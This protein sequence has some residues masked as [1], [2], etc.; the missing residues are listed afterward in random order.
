MWSTAT[1]NGAEG[2]ISAILLSGL[3]NVY[4]DYITTF[5]EYQQQ[6]Y[7]G[8]STIYGPHTQRAHQQQYASLFDSLL[9]V[10]NEHRADC[11]KIAESMVYSTGQ[12]SSVLT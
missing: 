10:N 3:S 5:E 1:D 11:R 4:T 9:K 12:N 8:A 2:D 7:E 6:R